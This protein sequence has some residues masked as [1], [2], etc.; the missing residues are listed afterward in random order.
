MI[1]LRPDLEDAGQVAIAERWSTVVL[2]EVWPAKAGVT[3]INPERVL[4]PVSDDQPLASEAAFSLAD[5]SAEFDNALTQGEFV[6]PLLIRD[7]DLVEG[8]LVDYRFGDRAY[9]GRVN[10]IIR[11]GE[12][13]LVLLAPEWF[14]VYDIAD[15]EDD[16]L[17]K[18]GVYPEFVVYREGAPVAG[19]D[20]HYRGDLTHIGPSDRA[21][22]APMSTFALPPELQAEALA[23]SARNQ[24]RFF[25]PDNCNAN[26]ASLTF[27]PQFSLMPL[28]AGVYLEGGIEG[29]GVECSWKS[30]GRKSSGGA[31]MFL[32]G[33]PAGVV[34]RALLGSDVQMAPYGEFKL[35]VAA[36]MP[37][38]YSLKA[39]YSVRDGSTFQFD[40]L[41]ATGGSGL[42]GT[43]LVYKGSGGLSGGLEATLTL[44]DAES[45][46]VGW[47]ISKLGVSTPNIGL[48]AK[49]GIA[50][51]AELSAANSAAVYQNV[52]Q[53]GG[54]VS[55]KTS[56]A[57]GASQ[58]FESLVRMLVSG[59]ELSLEAEGTLAQFKFDAGFGTMGVIDDGLGRAHVHGLHV[60][61]AVF[62]SFFPMGSI[63]GVMGPDNQS[64]SIF[65]NPANAVTYDFAEC[66]AN[67][68][69][70]TAPV[71]ACGGLFCG[72]TEPVEF[73]GGQV[74]ID[75]V[76][77]SGFVGDQ[78]QA[79]GRVG[80]RGSSSGEASPINISV[81]GNPLRPSQGS[82]SVAPGGSESFT[83]RA[84]CSARG[85]QQGTI[86]A[87]AGNG[88]EDSANNTV[89]CR[90][91]PSEPDCDRIWGHPHLVT[92]D[93]LGYDFNAT[94]D[95]I[96]LRVPGVDGLEV[97]GRFLAGYDGSWPQA[98]AAQVGADVVEIHVMEL[99]QSEAY[100]PYHYA[101]RVLVNGQELYPPRGWETVRERGYVPLPGGGALLVEQ[102]AAY[103]G[104]A[105]WRVDPISVLV[106]WP[107]DGPGQGYGVRMSAP[108]VTAADMPIAEIEIIRP[109]TH[110]GQERGLLGN[111]DGDPTNDFIRRNGQVLGQ[112]TPLNWTTLYALFGG[113]WL[114][115]S[116]ECLFRNG[117][118]SASFP[119]S[120]TILSPEQ[121]LLGEAA[122]R[123]LTGYYREA[124]IIDVGLTGSPELVQAYYANTDD[125][126]FMADRIVYPGVDVAVFALDRG[127]REQL[128]EPQASGLAYVQQFNVRRVT[129]EG[130]YLLRVRPPAGASARL[131]DE[132][133]DDIYTDDMASEV[134]VLCGEPDPEWHRFEE[135]QMPSAGAL[136]LW[137]VD[138]LTGGARDLLGEI[139][140][141]CVTA[142][143]NR[144]LAAGSEH[145]HAIDG[146]GVLFGW[147]SNQ[148]GQVGDGQVGW[149][150]DRSRPVSVDVGASEA[151][152]VMLVANGGA[153]SI[154]IDEHG[155]LWA[156]GRNGSGQLGDGST[157]RRS[158]PARVL[159]DE[160][161]EFGFI[162][163]AAGASH[164]LALDLAG[165]L[166]SWGENG[167][168]QLGDGSSTARLA[169]VAVEFDEAEGLQITA[170]AAGDGHSLALDSS[171]RVWAWGDNGRGQLGDG[172]TTPRFEPTPVSFSGLEDG[173][174]IAIAAGQLHSLAL[175]DSGRLWSWGSNNSRQLGDGTTTDRTTPV[176]V[177][178]DP[179]AGAQ[180]I[181]LS[182]GSQHN[183]ALDVTGRLWAWGANS[184]GQLGVG[185]TAE[186]GGL[187]AV[188]L[189]VLEESQPV[190]F[191]SGRNHNLV[192]DS[193]DRLWSWGLNGYGQVG[194]GSNATR[195]VP[196]LI[197]ALE[198]RG[199][200]TFTISPEPIRVV[201]GQERGVAIAAASLSNPLIRPLRFG[202]SGQGL[203][204]ADGASYI[205]V[206]AD[207]RIETEVLVTGAAVC[208]SVGE[209]PVN[210]AV[211]GEAG[212]LF[213]S[214]YATVS[215]VPDIRYSVDVGEDSSQ[216]H[217]SSAADDAY[218][219]RFTG[220]PDVTI[221]GEP[222]WEGSVCPGCQISIETDAVCTE[223]V[224][225]HLGHLDIYD[226]TGQ[227][228]DSRSVS[229]VSR[230]LMAPG[231]HHSLVYDRHGYLSAWG[232]NGGGEL[233]I[234]ETSW[235]RETP[236]LTDLTEL[237]DTGIVT[238]A[239]GI[240]SSYAIDDSGRL[241]AWGYN[242]SGQLGVGDDIE[243][244]RPEQVGD[245]VWTDVSAGGEHAL[246][247]DQS[248]RLW[249][250]GDNTFGQ[251]GD[252]STTARH[253]PVVVDLSRLSGAKVVSF[254]AGEEH[255]V[256]LDEIGRVWAWGNNETGRLGNGTTTSSTTP[257][258]V[259]LQPLGGADVIALSLDS[260]GSFTL[261]LDS[262]G[263]VWTWGENWHGS[264]GDGTTV[265]S[266]R[267]VQVDLSPL[268]GATVEAVEAGAYHAIL[269]DNQGRVWAWGSNYY[270]QLG[271]GTGDDSGVPVLVDLEAL[272]DSPVV[273]IA[274]GSSHNFLL[275]GNDRLWA[276]G[277][278]AGSGSG[279]A[280]RQELFLMGQLSGEVSAEIEPSAEPLRLPLG[281]SGSLA[282]ANIRFDN[283]LLRPIT[284]D[285]RD[286]SFHFLGA[287]DGL[288]VE[289]N[290][291][292]EAKLAA[293]G[294]AVCT[295]VGDYMVEFTVL[296]DSGRFVFSDE[297]PI[298][299][300]PDI[301]HVAGSVD[302]TLQL[303]LRNAVDEAYTVRFLSADD[304][305]L[306]GESPWETTVCGGCTEALDL[307]GAACPQAGTLNLGQL[308]IIGADGTLIQTRNVA[309]HASQCGAF[310]SYGAGSSWSYQLTDAGELWTWG[311]SRDG[312]LGNGSSQHRSS[313]ALVDLTALGEARMTR[314][315]VGQAHAIALDEENRLWAW[316]RN[317]HGQLG[318]GTT[319]HRHAP[320]AVDLSPL[321]EARVVSTTG[322][323]MHSLALDDQGR[324]WAWG[325]NSRGQLGDGTQEDRSI[326]VAVDLS[327]LGAARVVTMAAG[328]SYS[329]ALDDH[330]RVWVW[331]WNWHGVAGDGS[332]D[333][334]D[335][336]LAPTPVD[337][338]PM[339]EAQV[340]SIAAA[341]RFNL[342][343]DDQGRLWSWGSNYYG[344]SGNGT[345]VDSST[346][347]A[348]DLTPLGGEHFVAMSAMHNH[349]V[350]LDSRG[351]VWAW[352]R[353]AGGS[354]GDGTTD[355]RIV[356]TETDLAALGGV[357]AVSVA[358]GSHSLA[359]D[360]EGRLWAWG[361]NTEGA[362]GDGTM[363]NRQRPVRV[364][365]RTSAVTA[366]IELE[367]DDAFRIVEGSERQ[368]QIGTATF[369]NPRNEGVYIVSDTA[370]VSLG[371]GGGE[372]YL[373]ASVDAH[374]ITLFAAGA[375]A[376]SEAGELVVPFDVLETDG[377][378][379]ASHALPVQCLSAVRHGYAQADGKVQV[380]VS[381]PANS[382]YGL[383]FVG[384]DGVTVDGGG[385][386]EQDLCVGCDLTIATDVACASLANRHL[387]T[388]EILNGAGDVVESRELA[389]I[390][391]QTLAANGHHNLALDD[392]DRV[393]VWGGTDA[394]EGGGD[395]FAYA[396]QGV[397]EQHI[398]SV[399]S[400][401]S[402]DG[403][404][405]AQVATLAA[406]GTSGLRLIAWG[407]CGH[408]RP[409][410]VF[411]LQPS[412]SRATTIHTAC[413]N[414]SIWRRLRMLGW[415]HWQRVAST[416]YF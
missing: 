220:G 399:P 85:I 215:C 333:H 219:L 340:V 131:A 389:C 325:Y 335:I 225:R 259:D 385:V 20:A 87:S 370:A 61:N 306:D 369:F 242:Y 346:P 101:L 60:N 224:G 393:W 86:R 112:D 158:T 1:G 239:A 232:S 68:G 177:N 117:C 100:T 148:E 106:V 250:W 105:F 188:D 286:S 305:G 255:S 24:N 379:I 109:E 320:V 376:C 157:T 5:I 409:M 352:G 200:V 27:S 170:V 161:E 32:A 273:D 150:A 316:G 10:K 41:G 144:V 216:V 145:S 96:L 64:S 126:N 73:C 43:P 199:A 221:G 21:D 337:L 236:A 29:A 375:Q 53:S 155:Q 347:I 412:T 371:G 321:G 114:A 364:N 42:S 55:V 194:D 174:I 185:H 281:R 146:R 254:A 74:W 58:D 89:T 113:D 182:A 196:V 307:S 88:N 189:A 243:R 202:L 152:S 124:C 35:G 90:C 59:A 302:G 360:E 387:G 230:R 244:R 82:F 278:V 78:V 218:R 377:T 233:G 361:F 45:G 180:I 285:S 207:S 71:V 373:P 141:T 294:P 343:L 382:H 8:Q 134:E 119:T 288:L 274:A 356:P 28:D 26:S 331:G 120:A 266:P 151:I 187:V 3:A 197:G 34:L 227:L 402:R 392:R 304:A 372:V 355:E 69:N 263:R 326:P 118:Q 57:I 309:V 84:Q 410:T 381:N 147:G 319:T 62:R 397:A 289:G 168:G 308:E 237:G 265:P 125:L 256:L 198:G 252:G 368:V 72:L 37:A 275:D 137:S 390:E 403:W 301:T 138:V 299:C 398:H 191:V 203:S 235:R 7:A 272:G 18:E 190:A 378:L 166:W 314:I 4:F 48:D 363:E 351:R 405:D 192:L 13:Q 76:S 411:I 14:D 384:A 354:V 128:A 300:F 228:I 223:T 162:T 77:A 167:S 282:G 204:F 115:R 267:P 211:R 226:L 284:V 91:R 269:L 241:W 110:A 159:F 44:T 345:T 396:S 23:R 178:S 391:R 327:P 154:A 209:L 135:L 271:N 123:E 394:C 122:C 70:I 283:P 36:D 17:V 311:S 380:N 66:E 175:D 139:S 102:F 367:R 279:S 22:I 195:S 79:T 19:Y 181:A 93:G 206:P 81:S 54:A 341:A 416:D 362:L 121:R 334:D 104:S 47:L 52:G 258:A 249:A 116:H 231:T 245:R 366:Q 11:R 212:N 234:G 257:V 99:D 383:R 165:R 50:G 25:V 293:N 357:P 222:T 132:A 140:L 163:A 330:G 75:P 184:T 97:Q 414:P 205:S 179:L 322:G 46:A 268:N 318:D 329:M 358:A 374:R 193:Q 353:N 83:A 153:H 39:G 208:S 108:D 169:P 295:V 413:R 94:G 324:L 251:L 280:S 143:S 312:Q 142:D 12:Q 276:W 401:M 408:C 38:T 247:L 323:Y 270:W 130:S 229:C 407:A 2:A 298:H 171:G 31:G 313:P 51:G 253:T 63:N 92:A 160:T 133:A 103:G 95:Y 217:I 277:R 338:L 328:E 317:T 214:G 336:R 348:V 9:G 30:T 344:T 107:E 129:G 246:A 264:L 350:A 260:E 201:Q 210:L 315:G 111:N 127:P 342:A 404:G 156:W 238:L 183:L 16:F 15:A 388:L 261:V 173:R 349:V 149:N 176:Q 415:S 310:Q 332:A 297:T 164:S 98:V 339:G 56:V 262:E 287:E 65:E 172:T 67:G 292:T 213:G 6:L 136:Q 365:P 186:V 80:T 49:A 33:G 291:L 406:G 395:V 359:A 386:W 290:S 296:D 248:G 240:G 40:L 400:E 303:T